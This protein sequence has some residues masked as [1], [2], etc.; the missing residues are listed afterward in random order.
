MDRHGWPAVL[1]FVA[2]LLLLPP[3]YSS[4]SS[5]INQQCTKESINSLP[6]LRQDDPCVIDIIRKHYLNHQQPSHLSPAASSLSSPDVEHL[7]TSLTFRQSYKAS[8]PRRVRIISFKLRDETLKTNFWT[9]LSQFGG[10]FV[11]AGETQGQQHT[12]YMEQTLNWTGILIRPNHLSALNVCLSPKPYPIQ[13]RNVQCFPLYSILKAANRTTVDYLR[14]GN[15]VV[16]TLDVLGTIPWKLVDIRALS[17][18]WRGVRGGANGLRNFMKRQHKHTGL[19]LYFN[20]IH[21]HLLTN[22][23]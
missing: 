9:L 5:S 20:E 8:S 23:R 14:L 21:E 1:E 7:L 18:D 17:I 3:S 13:I 15:R 6:R 16:S 12:L 10:F 2:F 11:V 22:T 4:V 19:S